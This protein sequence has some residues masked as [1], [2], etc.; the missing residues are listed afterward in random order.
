MPFATHSAFRVSALCAHRKFLLGF[1]VGF[2]SFPH[3]FAG[4][5]PSIWTR[6]WCPFQGDGHGW[7][8]PG[9]WR[10]AVLEVHGVRTCATKAV[11]SA[12]LPLIL[13]DTARRTCCAKRC[14]AQ[15]SR[16]PNLAPYSRVQYAQTFPHAVR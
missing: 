13:A 9:D 5:P 3:Q 4:F 8:S 14:V 2:L 10:V 6:G 7:K 16:P 15:H 1:L 12:Q 11:V